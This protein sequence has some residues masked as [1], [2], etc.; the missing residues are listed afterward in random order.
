MTAN[1][2]LQIY[3]VFVYTPSAGDTLFSVS[4]RLFG[5]FDDIYLSFL[6]TAN[7]RYDWSCLQGGARIRYISKEHIKYFNEI[8]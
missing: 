7:R 5:S 1:E 3:P 6:K 2:L 8:Q 4:A